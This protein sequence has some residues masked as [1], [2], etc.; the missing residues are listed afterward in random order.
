M[1]RPAGAGSFASIASDVTPDGW[2]LLTDS[3]VLTV[4]GYDVRI[5]IEHD[6]ISMAPQYFY[7]VLKI[8]PETINVHSTVNGRIII[9]NNNAAYLNQVI[10]PEIVFERDGHGFKL[11][12]FATVT[13]DRE[14]KNAG[15]YQI[16]IT[17]NA[18]AGF[19]FNDQV[20]LSFT[21]IP[22]VVVFDAITVLNAV[23]N[24][25]AQ[26]PVLRQDGNAP[27]IHTIHRISG[28]ARTPVEEAVTPGRYEFTFFVNPDVALNYI[29]D[30]V[31]AF[32]EIGR[33]D[34]VMSV[35]RSGRNLT[36][37]IDTDMS[38]DT[39]VEFRV[40]GG[41]WQVGTIVQVDGQSRRG[42]TFRVSAYRNAVVEVRVHDQNLAS[43]FRLVNGMVSSAAFRSYVPL[44]IGISVALAAVAVALYF[45]IRKQKEEAR[46]VAARAD[47]IAEGRIPASA[48]NPKPVPV[49]APAPPKVVQPKAPK[50]VKPQ[51]PQA[52]KPPA[53]K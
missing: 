42:T 45:V 34:I 52:P 22:M 29:S 35:I 16:T 51:A 11:N 38:A 15:T 25:R 7:N 2:I 43:S 30:S 10:V 31:T 33:A 53:K 47:L 6:N 39:I 18:G 8:D 37:Y 20:V 14:V 48:A 23:F 19:Q 3:T 17:A 13:A 27:I 40:D 4:G 9:A 44:V 28:D 12:D 36:A 50:P 1:V 46:F 41:P 21:V 32:L 5:S 24:G 49:R 26:Q